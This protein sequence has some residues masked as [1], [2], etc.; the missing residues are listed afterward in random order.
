MVLYDAGSYVPDSMKVLLHTD[1]NGWPSHLRTPFTSKRKDRAWFISPLLAK[2]MSCA[3]LSALPTMA[4]QSD[5]LRYRSAYIQKKLTLTAFITENN[6]QSFKKE[7]KDCIQFS[8]F[9]SNWRQLLQ[10][11]SIAMLAYILVKWA[12]IELKSPN[13][14]LSSSSI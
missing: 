1:N 2:D 13:N 10:P 6:K 9:L 11:Y 12:C 4:A 14:F 3:P 7:F 8:L 5:W